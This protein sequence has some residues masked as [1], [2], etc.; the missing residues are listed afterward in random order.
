MFRANL[1]QVINMGIYYLL[2]FI[3]LVNL[4]RLFFLLLVLF[5]LQSH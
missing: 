2:F 4:L 5:G 1:L 3:C